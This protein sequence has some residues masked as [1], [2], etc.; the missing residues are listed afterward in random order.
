MGSSPASLNIRYVCNYPQFFKNTC[1][2]QSL[3]P[4]PFIYKL[5][6]RSIIAP[7]STV[8]TQSATLRQANPV[9]KRVL[10]KNFY[11]ML[12]WLRVIADLDTSRG[13]GFVRL[14][15]K[16]SR[17]SK[18]TITK[19]PM[20]HKTFSQEQFLFKSYSITL[21]FSVYPSVTSPNFF[22]SLYLNSVFYATKTDFGTNL[23]FLQ[24]IMLKA[25]IT[26][27]SFYKL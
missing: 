10:V 23:F 17:T 27:C 2:R 19:A 21:S 24:R 12:T 15:I 20:A 8:S 3:K 7:S 13:R 5:G 16:P 18:F 1:V 4:A 25:P 14:F 22:G 9:F 11:V 6:F 26:A